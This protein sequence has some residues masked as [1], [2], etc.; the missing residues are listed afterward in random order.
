M[1]SKPCTVVDLRSD[2]VTTP[3]RE[4][5]EAMMNADVGDDVFGDDPTVIELE[6][7]AA[8]ML[9]MEAA[10]FVPSGT[11]GN[12]IC[13]LTHCSGRGDEVL[14]GDESHIA[15]YEQGGVAQLGGVYP[16]TL[17]NFPD[18]TFDLDELKSRIL[19]DDPHFTTTRL[20][21]VE[22][23]HNRMGGRVIPPSFM[24]RLAEALKDTDI[25]IHVD[26]A[27]LFNAATT[28]K[29]P[30][31]SLLER[32][33]SVSICLS[34]ALGAPIGSIIAGRRDFIGR[35][36]RLRK[37]LGGGM[38][39]VG[40]LAAPGIIALEKMSLRLQE[41]HD[42]AQAFAK[43][44]AAMGDLGLKVNLESVESNIVFFE[45]FRDDMTAFEFVKK[46]AESG[47]GGRGDH[48]VMSA[49]VKTLALT[50]TRMRLIVHYQVSTEGVDTA[51]AKMR[52]VLERK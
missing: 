12:L 16:R 4:M 47:E 27:R 40:I 50:P 25:K 35:A 11:M 20:V 18:G 15:Y 45:V 52:A 21:C 42:R 14:L 19:P 3:T 34:K 6:R 22:N 9:G 26:G 43:G 24:D 36:H 1:S 30:V 8:R 44:I 2:T 13:V 31:A 51:L 28:L 7:L 10:L 23:T 38:R 49:S 39:Q 37:A 41:D 5:R 29:L 46:L 48:E 33:D 17:R 32:A